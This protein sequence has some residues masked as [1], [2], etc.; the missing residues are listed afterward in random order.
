VQS[1]DEIKGIEVM[2]GQVL[3]DWIDVNGH[4]NVAYYTLAFDQA[5]DMLWDD[6]GITAEHIENANSSTFAAEVHISYRRELN[7]DDPYL[8]TAQVLAFSAKGL[9]QFQRIYHAEK[10]YLAATAEWI[11]LHVDLESRRVTPW[12]DKILEAIRAFTVAQ[13][14]IIMP[15]EVGRV[16]QLNNPLF[17]TDGIVQ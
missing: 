12:P 5:I 6:F 13:G 14:D 1:E 16:M 11:N 7:A 10:N 17:R 2:R 8:L 3:P 4:M 15:D 9:H